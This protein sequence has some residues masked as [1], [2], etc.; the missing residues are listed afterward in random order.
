MTRY[1]TASALALVLATPLQAQ[2]L[3]TQDPCVEFDIATQTGSFMASGYQR[4]CTL[5][6]P[7]SITPACMNFY[8]RLTDPTRALDQADRDRAAAECEATQPGGSQL[9]G[10]A[11]VQGGYFDAPCGGEGEALCL[12]PDDEPLPDLGGADPDGTMECGAGL[13]CR[14]EPDDPVP[15]DQDSGAAAAPAPGAAGSSAPAD[16]ALDLA[17][18]QAIDGSNDPALYQAYLTQFPTGTFRPI[19]EARLR[20]LTAPPAPPAAPAAPAATPDSPDALFDRA[21]ALLDRVYQLAPNQWNSAAQEPVRLLKAASEAGHAEATFELGKLYDQG[22]GVSKDLYEAARLY[23]LAAEGGYSDGIFMALMLF[24]QLG[25]NTA[26]VSTYFRAMD[27]S[28]RAAF[29]SLRGSAQ[30]TR[31]MQEFLRAK[32]MWNGAVDGGVV[33]A[34]EVALLAYHG[35][36]P[37][38]DGIYGN[39][40][41][42]A[43]PAPAPVAQGSD[44]ARALQSELARVGCYQGAIDGLWGPASAAALETFNTW[45]AGTASPSRPSEAALAQV[46]A[47]EGLVCGVD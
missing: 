42:A 14:P 39:E 47:A 18:W 41:A 6:G 30:A 1:L 3:G 32:R 13:E 37:G 40:P 19:A 26:Y 45:M 25:D 44:L 16:P 21:Q 4:V 46:R 8:I 28:P 24:D 35:N 12:E 22:I 31:W 5:I 38:D 27:F 10:A 36:G 2:D 17:F 9:A 43:A 15:L 20:A 34:L 29:D 23:R 11:F 7:V 33:P